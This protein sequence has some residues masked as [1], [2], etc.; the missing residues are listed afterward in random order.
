MANYFNVNHFYKQSILY[1][2]DVFMFCVDVIADVSSE[3]QNRHATADKYVM[4]EVY[5]MIEQLKLK[6]KRRS[7][8]NIIKCW[9]DSLELTGDEL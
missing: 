5:H 9:S 7:L 2:D 4:D 1:M 6:K 8:K 3:N